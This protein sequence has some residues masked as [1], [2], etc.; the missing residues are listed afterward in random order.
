MARYARESNGIAAGWDVH[1]FLLAD[2]FHAFTGTAHPSRPQ[3][4]KANRY[5][6]LRAAL[7]AQKRR[8]STPPSE[9]V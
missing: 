6:Q 2:L 5:A 4:K 8:T 9:T 7:E 1:A 3:P